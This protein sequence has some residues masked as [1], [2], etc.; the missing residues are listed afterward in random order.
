MRLDGK[1]G[2]LIAFFLVATS[3]GLLVGCRADET[4]HVDTLPG[5]DLDHNVRLVQWKREVRRSER[6]YRPY[7]W[8]LNVPEELVVFR[9]GS[10]QPDDK[11]PTSKTSKERRAQVSFAGRI[12]AQTNEMLPLDS[13][14]GREGKQY[15]FHAYLTSGNS[16]YSYEETSCVLVGARRV[17]R[18]PAYFQPD[19]CGLYSGGCTYGYEIDGW[20]ISFR[21]SRRLPLPAYAYCDPIRDW[22]DDLTVYREPIPVGNRKAHPHADWRRYLAGYSPDLPP[23][24]NP[25]AGPSRWGQWPL[26]VM[27]P[28]APDYEAIA[29]ELEQNHN[30]KAKAQFP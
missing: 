8:R 23:P 11:F 27:Y 24:P 28:D 22:L 6:T 5:A 9:L 20:Y 17:A 30:I 10:T 26:D 15:V 18:N 21:I 3:V 7:V 16:R 29:A 2:R 1:L 25:N 4:G 13:K 14:I 12:D 19:G